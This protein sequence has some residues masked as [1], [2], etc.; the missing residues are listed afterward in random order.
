MVLPAR[1]LSERPATCEAFDKL[2][3]V[4]GKPSDVN[5][6]NLLLIFRYFLDVRVGLVLE[7]HSNLLTLGTAALSPSSSSRIIPFLS[8][9]DMIGDDTSRSTTSLGYVVSMFP[10]CAIFCARHATVLIGPSSLISNAGE[11]IRSMSI[12]TST[13][14]PYEE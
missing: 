14:H 11:H 3:G 9:S 8:A 6:P 5:A 13:R 10:T 7:H 4:I 1:V 2:Q 12:A